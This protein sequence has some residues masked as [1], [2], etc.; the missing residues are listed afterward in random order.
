M[1]ESSTT[2][3]LSLVR[4]YSFLEG[5]L[6][7]VPL[8]TFCVVVVDEGTSALSEGSEESLYSKL[9]DLG[10]TF[11]SIGQRSSLK[12]VSALKARALIWC[13]VNFVLVFVA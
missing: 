2:C 10:I 5:P 4:V 13:G 3:H 6:S 8:C 1:P 7:E 11:M 12:K 9:T